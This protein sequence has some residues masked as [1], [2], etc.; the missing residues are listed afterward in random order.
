MVIG[1]TTGVVE[2][3]I[4]EIRE[5]LIPVEKVKQGSLFSIRVNTLVRRGDKLYKIIK[6]N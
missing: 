2:E 1:A 4:S 3:I 5:D 6:A